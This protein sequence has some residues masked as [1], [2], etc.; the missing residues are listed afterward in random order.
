LQIIDTHAHLQEERFA[1]ELGDVVSRARRA[2]VC[3]MI[4]VG[5]DLASSLSSIELARRFPGTIFAAVGIHPNCWA[6][7]AAEDLERLAEL[8][9]APEVVAIGESGLD[10]HHPFT[11]IDAQVEGFRRHLRLAAELGKPILIHAR[12]ADERVLALLSETDPRP[13]GVRHCFDSSGQIAG[14]YV[15]LGFHISLGAAV[16][17]PGHR[18]LKAAA[19]AVPDEW[20]LVETDCPYQAPAGRAGQRNEPAFIV[21]TLHALAGLRGTAPEEL[22]AVTTRNACALFGIPAPL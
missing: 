19:R 8:A 11:P 7:A 13:S 10:L 6:R 3:G 21:D 17:R 22:A 1:D 15:E 9:A 4:C 14:R 2:G 16:T 18:K 5:T 20:L 12:K